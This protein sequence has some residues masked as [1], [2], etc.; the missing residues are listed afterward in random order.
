MVVSAGNP[1]GDPSELADRVAALRDA[2]MTWAI[3]G[4]G[5]GAGTIGEC[6]K[7][8]RQGPPR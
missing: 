1:M 4:F 8:I 6:R 7:R 5:S 2:G 3:Y